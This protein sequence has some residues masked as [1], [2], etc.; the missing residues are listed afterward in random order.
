MNRDRSS[1]VLHCCC[2]WFD[3]PIIW[4]YLSSLSVGSAVVICVITRSHNSSIRDSHSDELSDGICFT[5]TIN[6]RINSDTYGS[7][8]L[9][10]HIE[11]HVSDGRKTAGQ[12]NSMNPQACSWS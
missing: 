11:K 1:S 2:S 5:A 3:S 12:S 4:K 9:V 7:I 8:M 10:D 6:G